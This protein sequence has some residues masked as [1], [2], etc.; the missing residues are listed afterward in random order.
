MLPNI[1]TIGRIVLTPVFILCL[2]YE[3]PWAKPI[4]LFVF[5]IAAITDAVDG[6]LARKHGL[7][8]KTGAFLDPLA[9]K[10]LVSSAFISFAIMGKIPFWMAGL[11]IFRDLFITGLRMVFMNR[12]LTL[13][14]SSISK[15]KTGIQIGAIIFILLY[16]S[17]KTV[18]VV[19]AVIIQMVESFDLIYYA[20]FITTL[21]TVY[22]AINY[23]YKNR[24]VITEF[25]MTDRS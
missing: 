16:L 8:T 24:V 25:I 17:L 4:A 22:T 15:L 9:D 6:H 14:T 7:V 3:A 2:F 10:I 5:I 12:G 23:I 11:I 20:T 13:V 18:M 1:L 19:G 21:F